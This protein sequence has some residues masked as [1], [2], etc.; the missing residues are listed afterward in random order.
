MHALDYASRMSDASA[1]GD[2]A[3]IRERNL[4]AI[5]DEIRL[6]PAMSRTDLVASTSLS[7]PTVGAAV[8]ALQAGGLLQ[9]LGR[10][11]GRRGPTAPLYG[12]DPAAATVGAIDIG[13]RYVRAR[14]VDLG[15]SRLS[16]RSVPL[17]RPSSR[18]VMSAIREIGNQILAEQE[19][20]ELVVVGTPGFVDPASGLIGS[21]PNI[22]GW[23]GTLAERVISDALGLPVIVEN[24]VNLA[25]LGEKF[26]GA[27]QGVDS[28]AYLSIGSGLGAGLVLYGQL[29]SGAHGGA[30]E[31]GF[32]PMGADPFAA[33]GAAGGAMEARLASRARGRWAPSSSRR[34]R[35]TACS[36]RRGWA[37]RWAAPS[38][39]TPRARSHS[40]SPASSPWSTSSSC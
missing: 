32:L 4:H 36:R 26:D 9:E 28:F 35:S 38:S 29:Y 34:S 37:T 24:D 6:R 23:D 22:E 20:M 30:G 12:I 25:A 39:T 40:A 16:E 33:A 7:K 2:G 10:T 27:G 8:R 21:A 17:R 19:R 18:E 13:T 5:Y 14:V 31:V 15:G 3:A 11:T 1:L